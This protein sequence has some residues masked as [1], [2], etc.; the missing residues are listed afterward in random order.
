MASFAERLDQLFWTVCSP[1]TGKPYSVRHV[2]AAC[3]LSHTHLSKLRSGTASDPR[4]SEM[5]ALARFFGV[6]IDHFVTGG[7]RDAPAPDEHSAA[8]AAALRQPGVS[9]VAL[10]MVERRLSPEGAAA[11]IRI[12]DEV[13]RLEAAQRRRRSGAHDVPG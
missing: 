2:A 3:G 4:W 1:Q 5:E 12:I 11:V 13:A 8:L 10:R 9:Q 6:P 7:R